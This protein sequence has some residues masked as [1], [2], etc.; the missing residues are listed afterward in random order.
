MVEANQIKGGRHPKAWI[1]IEVE[2]AYIHC[3]KR[4]PL[5][6]LDKQIAWGTDGSSKVRVEIS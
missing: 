5:A 3:S 4:A 6:R 1:V 2:E